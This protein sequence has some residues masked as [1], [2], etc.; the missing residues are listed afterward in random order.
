MFGVKSGQ[1]PMKEQSEHKI[2]ARFGLSMPINPYNNILFN[3]IDGFEFFL[4][5]LVPNFSY[6]PLIQE[7][8]TA[9]LP[10]LGSCHNRPWTEACIV[11]LV[12]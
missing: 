5:F 8:T 2:E 10:A 11:N 4:I 3:H 12:L 6:L 7:G 9:E 1:K